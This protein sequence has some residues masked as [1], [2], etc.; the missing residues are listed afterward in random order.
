MINPTQ[1]SSGEPLERIQCQWCQGMNEKSALTCRSCG[2]P[3]D[4]R[5]LVSE[6]GWREAP[7]IKDM[8]EFQ[9][10]SSTC[11]VEG[12][13]VPVAEIHLGAGDSVFFEHHIM[14]WK[15]D[16]VP[17]T[18]LQL[19]G[20]M[21]RAF[22]GMPFIISVATGPGRI[23]FSR[24]ATGE[25]VVLPLHPGM[26]VDARE[27]AFL[28]G[29]HQIDYSFIR[30]KGFA[31]ILFGGQGMYMDRFV[32]TNTPGLLMLHG[33]GNVFERTLKS[34]ESIMLEPGAFL[35]KDS[36]VSMDVEFQKLGTGF[37]GAT[38]MALAKMTGPGR[39]GIQSM[40]VHHRTE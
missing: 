5:N 24:D 27:H 25:L 29:S 2:A 11:Q 21:K 12:E 20:G 34:G 13:I 33:Y 32:T 30:I 9:F 19:P 37:F 8:T 15:E 22:A 26:E 17:L 36:S 40:Y 6:S 1:A 7:R 23:A 28:L 39:V 16:S 3:L 10:S 35:Y 4:I 18:V 31:N 38:N 14:L